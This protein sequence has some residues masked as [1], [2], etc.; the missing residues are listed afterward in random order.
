MIGLIILIQIDL[1]VLFGFIV[2]FEIMKINNS[3][4]CLEKSTEI[5]LGAIIRRSHKV[6][7]L[8]VYNFQV[9]VSLEVILSCSYTYSLM[10]YIPF[11]RMILFIG[12]LFEFEVIFQHE[13]WGVDA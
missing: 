1:V 5:A 11:R 2:L 9:F 7:V 8:E 13:Y 12:L 3:I 6:F 4:K 10:L